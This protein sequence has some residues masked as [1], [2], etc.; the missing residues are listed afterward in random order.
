MKQTSENENQISYFPWNSFILLI[1]YCWEV[2]VYIA[3]HHNHCNLTSSLSQYKN[4]YQNISRMEVHEFDSTVVND[5]VSYIFSE[6]PQQIA[7]YVHVVD[8]QANMFQHI[9]SDVFNQ[10]RNNV[11]IF[12]ARGVLSK[13][14]VSMIIN[15]V[16]Y[17]LVTDRK[18]GQEG[19]VAKH[20]PYGINFL[21][22]YHKRPMWGHWIYDYL[23]PLILIPSCY[24]KSYS[25]IVH[26][27]IPPQIVQMF[28]MIGVPRSHLVNIQRER[29]IYIDSMI[30]INSYLCG[31][32]FLGEPLRKTIK[33]F[34]KKLKLSDDPPT[35]LVFKNRFKGERRY[36][37]N[38]NKLFRL[39]C[40]MYPKYTFENPKM[41]NDFDLLKTARDFNSILLLV[42]PTGSNGI[43]CIFMHHKA[44]LLICMAD[45]FDKPLIAGAVTNSD[46][47]VIMQEPFH[48]HWRVEDWFFNQ[49]LFKEGL[50]KAMDILQNESLS[51]VRMKQIK[52]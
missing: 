39:T 30:G 40:K 4:N 49:S 36:V 18:F 9:N 6:S 22:H 24:R 10:M 21:S 31:N 38:W 26:K 44:I 11:T 34:R 41:T 32:R 8:S 51:S 5:Y 19:E 12:Y 37:N 50:I 43:N 29:Y 16:Y 47:I 42:C 14:G 25:V 28:E 23:V 46:H 2:G 15:D 45:F 7:K 27:T 3:S 48:P 52:A 33:I 17:K 1:Y 20:L 13:F 35:R